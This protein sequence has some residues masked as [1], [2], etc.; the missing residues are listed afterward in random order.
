MQYSVG[1]KVE[2]IRGHEGTYKGKIYTITGFD[3]REWF[4]LAESVWT[5]YHHNPERFRPAK[6]TNKERI[7]KRKREYAAAV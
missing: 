2:C 3:H 1:Q 7:R 5:R 6:M 4:T